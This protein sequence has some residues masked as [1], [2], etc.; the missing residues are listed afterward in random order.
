MHLSA[1]SQ[2]VKAKQPTRTEQNAFDLPKAKKAEC[3][4]DN[5]VLLQIRTKKNI[6]KREN[7]HYCEKPDHY[8]RF[9]RKSVQEEKRKRRNQPNNGMY[10]CKYDNPEGQWAGNDQNN[11]SH[12]NNIEGLITAI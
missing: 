9:C 11:S 12:Q 8:D 7:C 2:I 4:N 10:A 1:L 6:K 3:R 5:H